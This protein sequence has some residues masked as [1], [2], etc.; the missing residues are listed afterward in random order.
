MCIRDSNYVEGYLEF[1]AAD[2][3]DLSIPFLGYVGDWGDLPI[4]D[5]V[6]GYGPDDNKGG[7]LYNLFAPDNIYRI[8]SAT[9][10]NMYSNPYI[11]PS[12]PCLLYTSRCV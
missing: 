1:E 7:G 5:Y 6:E 3:P 4:F 8:F 10:L 2:V 9:Q 11:G 12:Y